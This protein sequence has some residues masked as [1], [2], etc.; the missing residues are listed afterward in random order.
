MLQ[1]EATYQT[2]KILEA[3]YEPLDS[4]QI[5]FGPGEVLAHPIHVVTHGR[6]QFFCPRLCP[7]ILQVGQSFGFLAVRGNH[8]L[9]HLAGN[10]DQ[11]MCSDCGR[12]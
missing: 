4:M 11:H 1:G 2:G 10:T 9:P 3:G 7:W 5:V 12:E 8:V 6:Q